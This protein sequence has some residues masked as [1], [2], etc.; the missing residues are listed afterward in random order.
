MDVF[1]DA[2]RALNE[3]NEPDVDDVAVNERTV[4]SH[5]VK[6]RS[7]VDDVRRIDVLNEMRDIGA[8]DRKT[9]GV[10]PERAVPQDAA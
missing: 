8:V 10:V 7:A 5:K 9:I 6:D 4:L 2:V 1:Q 3:G